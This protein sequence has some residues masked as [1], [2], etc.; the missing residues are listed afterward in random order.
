VRRIVRTGRNAEEEEEEEE[1]GVDNA[2]DGV[3]G[4]ALTGVRDKRKSNHHGR[5][6][7]VLLVVQVRLEVGQRRVARGG[8][9]H[10]LEASVHQV[11]LEQGLE[12]PPH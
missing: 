1:E 7:G 6:L 4:Q 5:V 9:R 10:D 3:C 8:V 12:H 11:L 2:C